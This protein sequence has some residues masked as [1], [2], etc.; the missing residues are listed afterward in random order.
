MHDFQ[1]IAAGMLLAFIADWL[2]RLY[3]QSE[4]TG[5]R[6]KAEKILAA[7]GMTAH[8]YLATIGQEDGELR[9]A[10]DQFTLTGHIILNQQG[11]VVGK[12]VPKAGKAP[13][14]RLVVDNTK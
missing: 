8:L 4:N 3:R 1:M 9:R 6:V 14:L 10:L 7:H 2:L 11:N 5:A 13:H 12:V